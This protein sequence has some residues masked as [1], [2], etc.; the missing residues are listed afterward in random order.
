MEREREPE[1]STA[2][3]GSLMTGSFFALLFHVAGAANPSVVIFERQEKT[4][5]QNLNRPMRPHERTLE[6][7]RVLL[8]LTMPTTERRDQAGRFAVLV[9]D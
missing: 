6:S 4:P 7:L 3:A 1:V 9:L 2:A 8:L 5:A